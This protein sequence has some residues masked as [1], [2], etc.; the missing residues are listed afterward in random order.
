MGVLRPQ[1]TAAAGGS[2]QDGGGGRRPTT[3]RLAAAARPQQ[4]WCWQSQRRRPLPPVP[5]PER[6]TKRCYSLMRS[7]YRVR[8]RHDLL[9]LSSLLPPHLAAAESASR[10]PQGTQHSHVGVLCKAM[11][12]RPIHIPQLGG[13]SRLHAWNTR[14]GGGGGFGGG[15]ACLGGPGAGL[16][17][18]RAAEVPAPAPLCALRE[19]QGVQELAPCQTLTG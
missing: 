4:Q 17:C 12:V 18:G 6:R 5:P 11:F 15:G 2:R 13:H 19:R 7:W 1:H 8:C 3:T 10:P 9:L 16:S 14:G